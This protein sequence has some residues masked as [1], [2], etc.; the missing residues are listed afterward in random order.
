MFTENINCIEALLQR[1]ASIG[2]FDANGNTALHLACMTNNVEIVDCYFRNRAIFHLMYEAVID[3]V[4]NE[5][6][7]VCRLLTYIAVTCT[8][9]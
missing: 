2:I 6:N 7:L 3:A 5:G 9:I 8:S 1:N 4:N